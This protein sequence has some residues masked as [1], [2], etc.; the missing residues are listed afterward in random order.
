ML[1]GHI[2][3][4][5]TA[6]TKKWR[7]WVVYSWTM[8]YGAA[9]FD[10]KPRLHKDGFLSFEGCC[11]DSV[12]PFF[13]RELG[14]SVEFDKRGDKDFYYGEGQSDGHGCHLPIKIELVLPQTLA[15][16]MNL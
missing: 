10:H 7:G 11:C 5:M 8:G 1:Q 13:L 4:L 6:K 15:A 12:C 2:A 9:L 16:M 14:V 3:N